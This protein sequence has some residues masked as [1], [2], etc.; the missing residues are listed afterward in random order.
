MVEADIDSYRVVGVK[1]VDTDKLCEKSSLLLLGCL[2]V[3]F[4]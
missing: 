1:T 2:G 3:N 4:N